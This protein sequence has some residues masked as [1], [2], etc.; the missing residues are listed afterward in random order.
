MP[1]QGVYVITGDDTLIIDGQTIQTQADGNI[2]QLTRPNKLATGKIGKNGNGIVAANKTGLAADTQIR[3]LLGG[4]DDTFLLPLLTGYINNP[5]G[6][7]LLTG[8]FV[9][10]LGDGAGNEKQ[11]TWNLKGGFFLQDTD[12]LSNPEGNTDQAVAVYHL[13]WLSAIR[14]NG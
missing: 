9:K 6:F 7:A 12:G 5:V 10:N 2:F 4:A 13:Q 11:V 3:L 8:S 14:A 1:S